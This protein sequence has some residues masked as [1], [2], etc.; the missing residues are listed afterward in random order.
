MR[1]RAVDQ[2]E[3]V[4]GQPL[5]RPPIIFARGIIV[6]RETQPRDTCEHV[7]GMS[8]GEGLELLRSGGGAIGALQ[9]QF[10]LEYLGL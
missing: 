2:R 8:G 5:W 6:V 3:F 4:S 10:L 7:A 1:G 9:F